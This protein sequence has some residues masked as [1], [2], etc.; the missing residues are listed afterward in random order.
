MSADKLVDST[1]LD[2]D[3]ASVADAIRAKS[4]GSGQLA[5]P[6]GF[7]SAVAA[8][9]TGGGGA[10]DPDELAERSW[11]SGDVVLDSATIIKSESFMRCDQMTKISSDTVTT[12]RA[13]AFGLCRNLG[14]VSFPNVTSIGSK[15][16]SYGATGNVFAG[17]PKL[18]KIYLP[19]LTTVT[20]NRCFGQNDSW[21]GG[22]VGSSSYPATIALPA[23]SSLNNQSFRG[24]GSYFDAV[25][26]GPN[27]AT[28][29]T[30]CFYQGTF[31]AL[32]LRKSDA[33]V[34]AANADAIKQIKDVWVPQSLIS[35]YQTASN[36]SARYTAGTIT[37]HSIEGS[38]YETKYADG[39]TIPTT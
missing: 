18:T 12:I 2:A 21:G 32:I 13:C 9:P 26:F 15:D 36:W 37:F 38:I 39:T 1:Q 22:G 35:G 16:G 20:G 14:E 5:F 4:G 28:I 30:D 23:L 10:T 25:D 17:C 33:V 34:S 3:L 8:I 27:L 19:K 31:N 7:V 24:T 29:P 6:S 11:P